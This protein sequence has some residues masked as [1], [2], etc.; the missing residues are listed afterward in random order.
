VV[1]HI[2]LESSQQGR[3]LC[4][5]CH[6][7][8]RFEQEIMGIQSFKNPNFENFETSNLGVLRQ[9]DIWVQP[10]CPSTENTI[11][12]K[13]VASLK[14]EL[15]WVLWIR[16]CPWFVHAPKVIQL[17]T[18]QFW[19]APKSRGETHLRVSQSQVAES[20]DLE[21]RSRLPTLKK[22]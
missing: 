13:V 8:R 11:R 17:C 2:P 19:R 7:N 3:Q 20:W 21:A 6:L 10:L 5:K 15:W 14:F 1:C 4:F 9:N 16:V 22:G 18:N 12:G